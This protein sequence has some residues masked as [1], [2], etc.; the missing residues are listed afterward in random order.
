M[1]ID[2]EK[3][4]DTVHHD[5]LM[6]RLKRDISDKRVLWLVNQYLKAG[7]MVNG[8]VRETER[9][10]RKAVRFRRCCPTSC[11]MNWTGNWSDADTGLY[12]MR[13]T[14]AISLGAGYPSKTGGVQ[15]DDFWATGLPGG[16]SQREQ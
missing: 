9:E 1:D 4:F 15:K 10:R 7:V 14:C 6:A 16:E 12:A 8:V 13:M 5:R 2:L 11:W 3:F